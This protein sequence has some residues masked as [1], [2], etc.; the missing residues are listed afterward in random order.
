M[1]KL[2][3]FSLFSIDAH[4]EG[5]VRLKVLVS[6]AID[7]NVIID[8][9]A[10]LCVFL[11]VLHLD[12]VK[13]ADFNNQQILSIANLYILLVCCFGVLFD[14]DWPA[15][16]GLLLFDDLRGF[17]VGVGDEIDHLVLEGE[18]VELRGL[19]T[20]FCLFSL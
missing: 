3:W 1:L 15:A 18:G 2:E 11:A 16:L 14:Y 10:N 12:S 8:Y 19:S 9:R 5:T 13:P 4:D 6:L 20:E 7:C 17:I